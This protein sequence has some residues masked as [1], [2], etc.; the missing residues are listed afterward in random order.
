MIWQLAEA[1]NKFSEVVNRALSEG[2]QRIR[3]R[4]QVVVL[5]SEEEYKRLAGDR[6]TLIDYIRSGPDLS[7]LDLTRDQSPMRDVTW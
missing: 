4:D 1:K 6:E 3:R 2:P 7:E 5:L